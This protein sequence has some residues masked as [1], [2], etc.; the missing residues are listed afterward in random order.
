MIALQTSNLGRLA[1]NGRIFRFMS[2]KTAVPIHTPCPTKEGGVSA[3]A[4]ETP[5]IL[6]LHTL[7]VKQ[8]N[9]F[10]PV[11]PDHNSPLAV[12][13][14]SPTGRD[15]SVVLRFIPTRRTEASLLVFRSS[16][17]PSPPVFFSQCRPLH[18]E[19]LKVK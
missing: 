13:G 8:T 10:R 1:G 14:L 5:H 3:P 6:V 2:R 4:Q 19:P 16:P 17:F 11:G 18:L 9:C 7:A 12:A 15:G